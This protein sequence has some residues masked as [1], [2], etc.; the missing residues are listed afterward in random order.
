VAVSINGEIIEQFRLCPNGHSQH[1]LAMVEQ[2]LSEAGLTLSQCDVLAFGK[3][4]G[5]FTGLRIGAG[6]I[7]GMAFGADLPVVAVSSLA[8][9]AQRQGVGAVLAAFDARMGQVYWG[10]YRRVS[11][12]LMSP[13]AEE[14]VSAPQ[15]VHVPVDSATWLGAGS[16]WDR[17]GEQLRAGLGEACRGWVADAFPH[18]EDVARIALE[19]AGSGQALP[20]EQAL[21]SYIRDDVARKSPGR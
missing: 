16:G 21:P 8:A 10:P 19:L 3:G 4:P 2:V 13:C 14:R 6:V 11:S 17:F 18:A 9:L 5:S 12:G 15:D 7:Q 20:A 1:I